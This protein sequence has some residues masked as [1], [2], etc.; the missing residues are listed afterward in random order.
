[1]IRRNSSSSTAAAYKGYF[2]DRNSSSR[3]V[4]PRPRKYCCGYTPCNNCMA[5][6][7][8]MLYEEINRI[9]AVLLTCVKEGQQTPVVVDSIYAK[10]VT[11]NEFV[12]TE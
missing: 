12:A 9:N 1:M 4:P 8:Q 5:E 11:A 6:Q 10:T 2:V 7:I 3:S